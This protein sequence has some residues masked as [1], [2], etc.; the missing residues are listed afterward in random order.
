MA[1]KAPILFAPAMN[2]NMWESPAFQA[3]LRKIEEYGYL[4]VEPGSGELACGWEGKGRLADLSA[5]L[6]KAL[7]VLLHKPLNK[8][9]IIITAGPTREALD[10]VRFISNR[11]SGKMGFALARAATLWGAKVTLIA[12][13]TAVEPYPFVD[14]LVKVESARQMLNETKKAFEKAHAL[15]M[16]AAVA[17]FRP[18]KEHKKK[19][20]KKELLAPMELTENPDIVKTVAKNKGKKLIIGFA[21]ET[22]QVIEKAREKMKQKG[23]DFIVS[24]DVSRGDIGFES[25]E[26][27]VRILGRAGQDIKP[28]KSQK[29]HLAFDILKAVF[30]LKMDS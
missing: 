6:N 4:M 15:I 17:D 2:V 28:A 21:A 13:P 19:T 23:L 22:D 25:N 8:K 11:S 24:N 12:G 26:N 9:K 30:N 5:I 18:K 10:P 1:T 20:P 14:K 16:C 27:E 7:E 3:N 29:S